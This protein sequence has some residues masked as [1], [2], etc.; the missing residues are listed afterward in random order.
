VSRG[1]ASALAAVALGVVLVGTAGAAPARPSDRA[2]LIAWNAPSNRPSR[3]RLLAGRPIQRL[4]LLP[5]VVSSDT[6]R[7]GLAPIETATDACLLTLARPGTIE[8]V[9]GLW[10]AGRVRVWTFGDPIPTKAQFFRNVRLLPD[11]RV[12]KISRR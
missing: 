11:G 1:P 8:V 3:L 12:T 2:C 7:K 6:W 4:S 9:T 5:G 10:R